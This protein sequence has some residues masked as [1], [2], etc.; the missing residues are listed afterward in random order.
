MFASLSSCGGGLGVGG[1]EE[2]VF[3]VS[4]QVWETCGPAHSLPQGSSPCGLVA[5]GPPSTE[6]WGEIAVVPGLTLGQAE[7][8]CH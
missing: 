2:R 1:R 6:T 3:F 5:L 7:S 4:F 8:A